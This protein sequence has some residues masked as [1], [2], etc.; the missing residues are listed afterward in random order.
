[1]TTGANDKWKDK[2]FHPFLGHL[3]FCVYK[4]GDDLTREGSWEE[5][6]RALSCGDAL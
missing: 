4:M 5:I 2:P 1:M 3:N 6:S